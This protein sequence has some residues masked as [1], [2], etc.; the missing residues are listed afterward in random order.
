[1]A[2]F[3][4]QKSLRSLE[5]FR[6]NPHLQIPSKSP[7]KIS[8]SPSKI[9]IHLKF[10]IKFPFEFS[11]GS[12]PASPTHPEPAQPSP[13]AATLP[14]EATRPTCHWR[15]RESVFPPLD[16]S[17]HPRCLFTPWSLT[18][19]LHMSAPS[20][21]QPRRRRS[22]PLSAMPTTLLRATRCPV[23]ALTPPP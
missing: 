6:K 12:S 4:F 9:Q 17:F 2:C 8:Q 5:E 10:K 13:Q 18:C 7:Y 20:S 22:P 11:P 1:M 21:P 16:F 19:V 15:P 14:C 23:N 3:L